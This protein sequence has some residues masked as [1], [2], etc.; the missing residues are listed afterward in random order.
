MSRQRQRRQLRWKG[1]FNFRHFNR[2]KFLDGGDAFAVCVQ[3]FSR[4][5]GRLAWPANRQFH[6]IHSQT[7]R[8]FHAPTILLAGERFNSLR[9][10]RVSIKNNFNWRIMQVFLQ[11]H[12]I[13]AARLPLFLNTY[14]SCHTNTHTQTCSLAS[15][16]CNQVLRPEKMHHSTAYKRKT[17]KCPQI[18]ICSISSWFL[19]S[20]RECFPF[21]RKEKLARTTFLSLRFFLHSFRL[22]ASALFEFFLSFQNKKVH[23]S[24]ITLYYLCHSGE[25]SNGTAH[26][27]SIGR[28]RLVRKSP[29]VTGVEFMWQ[30]DIPT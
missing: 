9:L 5:F 11:I 14:S 2:E 26:T 22:S 18:Y 23:P 4:Y 30:R 15:I 7:Q 19:Y 8:L 24:P 1:S 21:Y 27:Y 12:L 16:T 29:S 20:T 3:N 6:R 17:S 25:G 13:A 28:W 10:W